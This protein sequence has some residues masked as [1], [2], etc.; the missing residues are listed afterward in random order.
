[1]EMFLYIDQF[2]NVVGGHFGNIAQKEIYFIRAAL[3]GTRCL[4]VVCF[5]E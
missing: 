1:M 5:F 4:Y 2:L 3:S